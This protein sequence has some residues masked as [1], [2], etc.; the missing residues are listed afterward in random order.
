M[1]DTSVSC[2][3][4]VSAWSSVMIPWVHAVLGLEWGLPTRVF[5][6]FKYNALGKLKVNGWENY[7]YM[8][9][10]FKK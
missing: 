10:T 2:V 4:Y 6:H 1:V 3:R 8:R 5:H 7:I 9:I